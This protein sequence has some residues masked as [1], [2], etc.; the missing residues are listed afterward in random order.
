MDKFITLF[1]RIGISEKTARIYLT[2]LEHGT[3]SIA[4]I[5]KRGVLH[6]A[7]VYR[8]IPYLREERLIEETIR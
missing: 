7:E 3:S 8:A 5:C 4:D 1:E 6:R 2:L